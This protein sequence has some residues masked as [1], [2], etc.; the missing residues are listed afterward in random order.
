[1]KETQQQA[2]LA[3]MLNWQRAFLDSGNSANVALPAFQMLCTMNNAWLNAALT[4]HK[5]L[6]GFVAARLERDIDLQERLA[7]AR[8]GE[9]MAQLYGAFVKDMMSAY[10]AEASTLADI[11]RDAA[12]GP[13]RP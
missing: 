4:F 6:S 3:D 8:D 11:T 7:N 10:S 13:S 2:H 5:E 9:D 12:N 1:M